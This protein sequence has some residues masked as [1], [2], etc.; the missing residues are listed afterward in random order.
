MYPS[1]H[2]DY[3]EA[4]ADLDAQAASA[5]SRYE[6]A[7]QAW[8]ERKHARYE[9]ALSQYRALEAA[10]ETLTHRGIDPETGE[11]VPLPIT[12]EL[13]AEFAA[14]YEEPPHPDHFRPGPAEYAR[15]GEERDRAERRWELDHL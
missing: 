6:R 8:R 1:Q 3:C 9:V 10:G 11:V 14:D 4:A 5:P 12:A 2:P 15:L 13:L 7:L